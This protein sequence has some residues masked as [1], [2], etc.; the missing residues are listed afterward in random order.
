MTRPATGLYAAM[1]ALMKYA[2]TIAIYGTRYTKRGDNMKMQTD[3]SLIVLA[4][5]LTV[6]ALVLTVKYADVID[7]VGVEQMEVE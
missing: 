5:V 1:V 7:G 6:A 4:L 2:S 3:T